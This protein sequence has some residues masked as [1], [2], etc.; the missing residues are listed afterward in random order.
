MTARSFEPGILAKLREQALQPGV[1]LD[2]APAGDG[3]GLAIVGDLVALHG[4]ALELR[5]GGRGGLLVHLSL[6]SADHTG[7]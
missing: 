1:R 6:L 5:E 4:R 2:E 7:L 3:S